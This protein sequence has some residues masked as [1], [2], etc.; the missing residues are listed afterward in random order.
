MLTDQ[1]ENFLKYVERRFGDWH[2]ATWD[3]Q[4]G[5]SPTL[6]AL[7]TELPELFREMLETTQISSKNPKEH[8]IAH[9]T[10][11][12]PEHLNYYDLV[13]YKVDNLEPMES[14]A[15]LLRWKHIIAY[16]I[17]TKNSC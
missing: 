17:V 6:R 4:S 9:T 13:R 10:N 5:G 14:L 3:D 7:L 12:M 11:K 15:G 8:W 1:Q 2:D 16:Q